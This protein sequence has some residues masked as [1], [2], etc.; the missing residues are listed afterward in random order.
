MAQQGIG[1]EI[2]RILGKVPG[3]LCILGCRNIELGIAAEKALKIDGCNVEAKLIDI[4]N[5]ASIEAFASKVQQIIMRS[6][7]LPMN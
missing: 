6:A 3:T 4:S 5:P 7:Y 1:F 2:A